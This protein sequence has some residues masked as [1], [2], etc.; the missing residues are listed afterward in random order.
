MSFTLK[1][2]ILISIAAVIARLLSRSTN[3]WAI[4]LQKYY[5][6]QSIKMSGHPNGWNE[7][8][9]LTLFKALIIFAGAMAILGAYVL[10]FTER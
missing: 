3:N 2:I 10:L 9:K 5:I 6:A 7:K 8:W 1:L 4:S